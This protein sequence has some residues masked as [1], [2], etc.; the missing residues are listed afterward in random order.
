[1]NIEEGQIL[2]F[3]PPILDGNEKSDKRRYM[4]VVNSNEET[5]EISMLNV[6][7]IKGKEAKLLMDSNMPI[8]NY[9]PLV[10]PSFAKLKTT[11]K[12]KY[13]DELENYVFFGGTKLGKEQLE[14]IK[15]EKS[16]YEKKH[17]NSNEIVFLRDEFQKYNNNTIRKV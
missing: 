1:M 3:L 14:K 4:L 12:I 5:K 9:S 17:N 15:Y 2:N 10:V 6:S 16:L 13:F 11:Y 8:E 7:S